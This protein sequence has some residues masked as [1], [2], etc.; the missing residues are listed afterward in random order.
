MQGFGGF[1]TFGIFD[2]R[3]L[4][5]FFNHFLVSGVRGLAFGSVTQNEVCFTDCKPSLKKEGCGQLQLIGDSDKIGPAYIFS[6][7]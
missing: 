6:T 7:Y 5:K 2:T 3:Y 4:K 1:G